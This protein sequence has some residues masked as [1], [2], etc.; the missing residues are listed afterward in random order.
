MT[1]SRGVL[2]LFSTPQ[3]I[4]PTAKAPDPGTFR[5]D[6]RIFRKIINHRGK[7]NFSETKRRR[8]LFLDKN[9]AIFFMLLFVSLQKNHRSDPDALSSKFFS[10]TLYFET[11]FMIEFIHQPTRFLIAQYMIF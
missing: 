9:G 7:Y 6:H 4:L 1:S 2:D 5:T 8:F 11:Q 10:P 3:A